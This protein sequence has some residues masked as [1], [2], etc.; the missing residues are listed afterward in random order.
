MKVSWLLT[1]TIF[2]IAALVVALLAFFPET[3]PLAAEKEPVKEIRQTRVIE[4]TGASSDEEIYDDSLSEVVYNDGAVAK[5]PLNSGEILA[6]ALNE[7]FDAD[8][9]EEQ[10]IA[11]RKSADGGEIV[12][13]AYIDYDEA[14]RSYQRVWEAQTL[15]TRSGTLEL[16]VQDLVGD[17]VPCVVA[18]GMNGMGWHTLSVFRKD[19]QSDS[20]FVQIADIQIEGI[21]S[22]RK[23]ERTQA[24]QAGISAGKPF[25]IIAHGR[26]PESSNILDQIEVIYTYNIEAESYEESGVTRIPG[27]QVEEQR[28]REVLRG[29]STAFEEFLAGLW[30]YVRS[31]GSMDSS[32]YIYFNPDN[33]EIV[34]FIDETQQVFTWQSSGATR[35]G[36]YI[37][38]QNISVR[39][40]RRS[41]D[42][43]IESIEGIRVKVFE[44]VRLKIGNDAGWD[45]SYRKVSAVIPPEKEAPIVIASHIEAA[46]N[47][48]IG[49]IWF[50]PDGFYE[51]SSG[52]NVMRGRYS[53][54]A[55][56]GQE[57][58]ELR[59]S[60]GAKAAR[61]T[62]K[63]SWPEGNLSL[64]RVHIGALGVQEFHEPA[65]L[66]SKEDTVPPPDSQS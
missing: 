22:I 25:T 2:F 12:F 41:L 52:E 59:G 36:L 31:D 13:I 28:V 47:G 16:Y 50:S 62:F 60:T 57:M 34:F 38:T 64:R 4:R 39:T 61:E 17:R 33:E 18:S 14:L 19:V 65:V 23:E 46:Y 7:N 51:L 53:F 56:D 27:R 63:V 8:A 3:L 42:I 10:I 24:Y 5:I 29:G 37:S 40:L 58:L 32:H 54:Y 66:L 11:Y 26:D 15:I 45:G 55:L 48:I 30:Y 49:R 21:V 1:I 6:G 44:D 9:Q 35:Y 43:A 20:A